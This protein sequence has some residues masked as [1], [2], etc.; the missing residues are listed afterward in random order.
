MQPPLPQPLGLT[1][2]QT[3]FSLKAPTNILVVNDEYLG[4]N[5]IETMLKT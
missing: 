1:T 3:D 2:V 5:G 4:Y